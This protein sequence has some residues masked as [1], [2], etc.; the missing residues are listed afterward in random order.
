MNETE[1]IKV[2]SE[3]AA[4]LSCRTQHANGCIGSAAAVGWHAMRLQYNTC[5]E[6]APS[7]AAV[8]RNAIK[9]LCLVPCR[10]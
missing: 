7:R 2:H 9:L 8:D 4:H 3:V 10:S 5:N 1:T 6:R